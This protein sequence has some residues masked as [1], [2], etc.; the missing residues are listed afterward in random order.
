VRLL[1][2]SSF[3]PPLDRGG[4]DQ[5]CQE[6]VLALQRHGHTVLVLTSRYGLSAGVSE[7]TEVKRSLYLQADINYYRPLDFFFSRPAQERSNLDTLKATIESFSPDLIIV[8]NVWNLS[9]N[10]PYWAEQW[11]PGRVAYYIS[12]TW[13]IDLDI[14]VEYWQLPARRGISEWLK[15]PIREMALG[16][17]RR[18]G[19]P[20]RLQF[21]HAKCCSNFVRTSLVQ[22]GKLPP[23]AGILYLGIDPKP[24]LDHSALERETQGGPLRLLYFGALLPMKGVHTSIEA[25]ALLQQRGLAGA[26]DLTVLGSGHPDYETKLRTK[27]K[28]LG[29]EDRVHFEGWIRRDEVPAWLERFDVFLFTSIGREAMARTV[30][31]AMAAGLLVLGAETGGQVEMLRHEQNAL[32]FEAGD[33]TALATQIERA[34]ADPSLRRRLALAGRQTILDQFTLDRMMDNLEGWLGSIVHEHSAAE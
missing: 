18:E 10:L 32:T 34:I 26:V 30:M 15:W 3:Y 13:P 8:W 7:S 24:Y 20:P 25:L 16:Q 21:E 5:L 29:L 9:R 14:H 22:A 23:E 1:F 2:L 4:L 28:E 6:A 11:L 33:A 12:A 19:Y 27:V 31:E 17:L